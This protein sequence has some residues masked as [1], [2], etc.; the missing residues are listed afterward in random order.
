MRKILIY[1]LASVFLMFSMSF[2]I[3]K[4]SDKKQERT[5]VDTLSNTRGDKAQDVQ[6]DHPGTSG[7][8]GG[9]D[10]NDFVDRNNNGID[11][12]SE[13]GR[14]VTHKQAD[15]TGTTKKKESK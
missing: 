9:K 1:F 10:Y 8:T 4:K 7:S 14:K 3:D 13:G 2:A 15:S 5:K 12:R 6:K 11:D